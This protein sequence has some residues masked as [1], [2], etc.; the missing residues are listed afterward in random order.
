MAESRLMG[1]QTLGEKQIIAPSPTVQ[2]SVH[3]VDIIGQQGRC[4]C[5][6][7]IPRSVK[8]YF[9]LFQIHLAAQSDQPDVV[10][11]FLQKQPSLVTTTT[12]VIPPHCWL[13][14]Y[15]QRSSIFVK[16]FS[17]GWEHIRTHRSKTWLLSRLART[18][19]IWQEH[20]HHEQVDF[21]DFFYNGFCSKLCY[22]LDK[23]FMTLLQSN[24]RLSFRY[25]VTILFF[26]YLKCILTFMSLEI[27]MYDGR[28]A[29]LIPIL[30]KLP[31]HPYVSDYGFL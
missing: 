3:F 25:K 1:K 15:L 6:I 21:F 26:Q 4:L 9:H 10:K 24:S 29:Y 27:I 31:L 20:R 28:Y 16:C 30:V 7:F 22:S 23:I 8:N 14:I 11:L 2:H 12:K 19:Q 17:P 5:H 13:H 18:A